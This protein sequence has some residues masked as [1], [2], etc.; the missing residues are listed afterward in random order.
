M[1]GPRQ[2]YKPAPP[3]IPPE[4]GE[5]PGTYYHQVDGIPCITTIEENGTVTVE[6]M[7]EK[8]REE[9]RQNTRG[10]N[11]YGWKRS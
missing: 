10:P 1:S 3:E 5:A 2:G 4:E 6:I 7:T 9:V 11:A 8:R